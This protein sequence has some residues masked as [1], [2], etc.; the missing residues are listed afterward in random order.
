VLII[1][2]ICGIVLLPLA[3]LII[4]SIAP[5]T[6]EISISLYSTLFLVNNFFAASQ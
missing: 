4:S 2:K 3:F 6:V 5:S 1:K